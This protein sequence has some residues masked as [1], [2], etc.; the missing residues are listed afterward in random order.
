MLAII[1]LVIYIIYQD[2]SHKQ[3]RKDLYDRI[4]PPSQ[5]KESRP[6]E[7]VIKRNMRERGE[8]K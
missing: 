5:A 6:I 3:E 4:M 1:I 7:N 2:I 8:N